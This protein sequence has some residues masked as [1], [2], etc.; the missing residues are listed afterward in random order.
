MGPPMS[1]RP[2]S[3][4]KRENGQKMSLSDFR[5]RTVRRGLN[6]IYLKA[7]GGDK[8]FRI[9][10]PYDIFP[11]ARELEK[12]FSKVKA[13]VEN[14]INL[15]RPRKY[16]E[17]DP[18]RAAEVSNDWKIYYAKFMGA[19]NAEAIQLLPTVTAFAARTP[20]VAN[21]VVSVLEPRVNLKAHAGTSGG[22]VRYHLSLEVP[23]VNPPHIRV[24]QERYTWK[25]GESIILDDTFD[26]EVYNECDE[27]R[28]VLIVDIFRPMNRFLDGI[29]RIHTWSRRRAAREI[30]AESTVMDRN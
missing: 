8:R 2:A 24:D 4:K 26:H 5:R 6:S 3:T 19:I 30:L 15:S 1:P 29:N 9:T 7:S 27:R 16:G 18:E 14:L 17:F 25:E 21:V 12:D 11:E 28:I 22:F 23:K 20:R 13:E 10:S